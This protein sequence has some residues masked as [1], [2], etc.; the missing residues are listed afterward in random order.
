M[1]ALMTILIAI[2]SFSTAQAWV[3]TPEA[4]KE[5]R[6]VFR[7]KDQASKSMETYEF[8]S[9]APSYEE[10]FRVAASKCYN[11]FRDTTKSKTGQ[12]RLTEDQGLDIIDAC[13]NP[14]SL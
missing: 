3:S 5:H 14:R 13:A 12:S 11:H 8:A 7:M 4:Q 9:T 1:K 10:A 2:F 6:F